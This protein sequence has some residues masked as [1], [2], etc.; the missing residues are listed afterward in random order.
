MRKLIIFL[1]LT[2]ISCSS[3]DINNNVNNTISNRNVINIQL[4]PDR[5]IRAADISFLPLIESEGTIYKHAGIAQDAITTLKNAGCNTIRIRLW[6][7]PS[8]GHSGLTEVKA[9][10]LRVKAAGLKVWLTVHYSDTW[11][12]PGSQTKPAA[13]NSMNFTN[14]K[15]AVTDYTTMVMTEINPDIIQIGNETNDGMLWPEGK[16]SSNENQYLQLITAASAAVRAQ[17]SRTKI[18]LHFAGITSSDWYFNKVRNMDFD[19]IGMSYYPIFHGSSLA[20][21]QTK[22]NTLGNL[23]NK[24]VV[25]AETAYPFTL[26]YNDFTNN[27]VGL[28]SQLIPAYSA[29]PLGQKQFLLALKNTVRTSSK[30]IG[31]CYWGGEWLAFRGPTATN[32]STYE[33]QALWDFQNNSVQAMDAFTQN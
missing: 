23:Y 1:L 8:D 11:A 18:M 28:S 3:D 15:I 2:L 14:L 32:G 10:A 26:G 13:W 12:D 20:N 17:S 5:E 22:M 25:I 27:I 31:F 4:A 33:N 24:K 9:L 29:T 30:G 19:Y 16:L 21:L 7:T 6:H